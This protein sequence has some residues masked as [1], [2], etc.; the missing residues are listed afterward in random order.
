MA[1]GKLALNAIVSI[2]YPI[3][4]GYQMFLLTKYGGMLSDE[5]KEA[6]RNVG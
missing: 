1:R 6:L 4:R 3:S 5:A 2:E